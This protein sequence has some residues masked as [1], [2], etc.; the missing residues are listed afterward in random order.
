MNNAYASEIEKKQE[1]SVLEIIHLL[2][3]KQFSLCTIYVANLQTFL[4]YCDNSNN[5][6][7]VWP[8]HVTVIVLYCGSTSLAYMML[9]MT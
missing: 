4:R 7:F 2:A 6:T 5:A 3:E 1:T 8:E 9:Y